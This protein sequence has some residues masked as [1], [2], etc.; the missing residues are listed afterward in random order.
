MSRKKL[1][2]QFEKYKTSFLSQYNSQNI[3]TC[4]RAR[5][6]PGIRYGAELTSDEARPLALVPLSLEQGYDLPSGV[7]HI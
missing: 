2:I 1:P 5:L 4:I 6:S 3:N 7:V